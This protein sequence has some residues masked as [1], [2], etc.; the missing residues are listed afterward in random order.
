[1]NETAHEDKDDIDMYEESSCSESNHTVPDES[2]SDVEKAQEAEDKATK[3][4]IIKKEEEAV[5]NARLLV[6]AAI[7][8]CAVAVSTAVYI[9]ASGGDQNSFE[10]EVSNI[11]DLYYILFQTDAASSFP[12]TTF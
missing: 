2:S 9:F 4:R 7:T 8:A 3:D 12:Q 1:M 11:R 10:S 5:R 6:A